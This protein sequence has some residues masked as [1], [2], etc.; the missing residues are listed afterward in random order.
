L[1]TPPGESVHLTSTMLE[2]R[3]G[4]LICLTGGP[5]GPI[6]SALKAD[7]RDLAEQRLLFLKD[8]FGD[9]LYVEL[10]R[11]AGYDRMVEKSTVDLAYTHELP[12]VATN[13]AFFSK[14]EDYEAHDALI[15]IAE[16]SV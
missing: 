11:V 6:G 10:E 3:C 12:L 15:A 8:L 4:G 16:G 2:D 1:E 9:R 14:R 13:E 7:R 5:R